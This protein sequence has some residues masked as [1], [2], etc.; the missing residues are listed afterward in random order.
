M[1]LVFHLRIVGGE[2]QRDIEITDDLLKAL[3]NGEKILGIAGVLE[4]DEQICDFNVLRGPLS[5]SGN[6]NKAAFGV[7]VDDLCGIA[8]ALCVS[9][10]GAAEL[11]GDHVMVLLSLQAAELTD[12]A[13]F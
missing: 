12:P 7:G 10:R 9:Q 1:G 6:D 3:L 8:D 11:N 2:V 5:R 4:A 13:A